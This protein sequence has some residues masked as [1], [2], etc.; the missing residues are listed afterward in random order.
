MVLCAEL[1]HQLIT[2]EQADFT[3]PPVAAL[4]IQHTI[5]Q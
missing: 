4:G 5:G 3:D 1:A 2:A